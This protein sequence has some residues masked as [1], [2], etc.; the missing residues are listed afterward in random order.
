[1]ACLHVYINCLELQKLA[2]QHS[3]FYDIVRIVQSLPVQ[4]SSTGVMDDVAKCRVWESDTH[5]HIQWNLP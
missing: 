2:K 1:M 4:S 3:C 5:T